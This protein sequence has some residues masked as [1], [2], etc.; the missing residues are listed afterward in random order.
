MLLNTYQCVSGLL[1]FAATMLNDLSHFP[2]T[3][4]IVP[5]S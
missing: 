3:C 5:L 4:H 2:G 1:L